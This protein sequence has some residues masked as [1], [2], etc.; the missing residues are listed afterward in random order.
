MLGLDEDHSLTPVFRALERSSCDAW[1]ETVADYLNSIDK[2]TGYVRYKLIQ[3]FK[4]LNGMH[5]E[6][7]NYRKED[8]NRAINRLLDDYRIKL[9]EKQTILNEIAGM[10]DECLTESD[11]NSLI[12]K[13]IIQDLIVS[14]D[15]SNTIEFTISSPVLSYEKAAAE[16]YYKTISDNDIVYK[17]LFKHVFINEDCI[18]HFTDRVR[19]DFTNYSYESRASSVGAPAGQTLFRNPHHSHYNCWGGYGSAIT[20]LIS[21]FNFMQLFMQIKAAVGS[22]NMTDYTVLAQFRLDT[23][24]MFENSSQ[25]KIIAFRSNPETLYTLTEA[26]DIWAAEENITTVATPEF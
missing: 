16:K 17:T 21:E 7:L 19:I 24:R 2:Y 22:L 23:H 18:L 15:S 13:G 12:D 11:I 8:I 26:Y 4:R 25:P 9:K 3:S 20:Q 10:S 14:S 5:I 1:L 6:A